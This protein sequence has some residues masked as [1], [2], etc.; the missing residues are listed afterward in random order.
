MKYD[1]TWGGM[2]PEKYVTKKGG[3]VIEGLPHP[4]MCMYVFMCRGEYACVYVYMCI[5]HMCICV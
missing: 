4:H 1:V 5:S 3:I 2:S